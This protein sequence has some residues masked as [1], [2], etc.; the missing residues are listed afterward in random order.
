MG[1]MGERRRSFKGTVIQK[2]ATSDTN[3]SNG[4]TES[5]EDSSSS[6]S[7]SSPP[8]SMKKVVMLLSSLP[9]ITLFC[10]FKAKEVEL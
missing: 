2:E 3:A 6:S 10:I 5:V 4:D 8:S 1:H 9:Q 7:S